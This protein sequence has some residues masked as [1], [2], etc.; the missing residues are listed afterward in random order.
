MKIILAFFFLAIGVSF[1]QEPHQKKAKSVD[2]LLEVHNPNQYQAIQKKANYLVIDRLT[3]HKRTRLYEGD[4]F[5]F[6][7]NTGI[8]FQEEISEITDSTFSIYY[9]DQTDRHLKTFTYR[10]DEI[11]KYYKRTHGEKFRWGLSWGTL[12]A[13]LPLAYDWIYYK[14]PPA[15][16]R[17]ALI[18]IPLIQAANI[19]IMNRNRYFNGKRFN[20]NTQL[21]I[22]KG[23]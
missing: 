14:V 21:K 10:P 19:L 12:G 8:V 2:E 1:A 13:F 9:Y 4:V 6:K 7:T 15:Q 20:D 11:T 5:R 17:G 22:F 23:H 3:A 16:N 18:G